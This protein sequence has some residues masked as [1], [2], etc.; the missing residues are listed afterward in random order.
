MTL[1]RRVAGNT[2]V[3][4]AGQ[5]VGIALS[6]VFVR[7]TTGHLGVEA[8]GEF[9]IILG[10][11]GIVT[12]LA[13][14]GVTTTLARELAKTP[15][16]ADELGGNLLRFRFVS[17]LT[18]ALATLAIL[19]V[20]PYSLETKIGLAISLVGVVFTT[21]A[22]FPKA[23]FQVHL[24]LQR[25][26][27]LDIAQKTLNVVAISV[28]IALDAELI[29][30][31]AML[32][33]VNLIVCIAA[34]TLSRPFWRPNARFTWAAARPLLRDTLGIGLVMMVGVLH[35]KGDSVLLSLLRPPEDVGD[36]TIAYRFVEQ[37]F[38]LPGVLLAAIFPI[39][40]RYASTN[41]SR[42]GP[43]MNR[44]FQVL[45]LAGLGA[46]LLIFTLSGPL[47]ELFAGPG[48]GGAVAP[49]RILAATLPV[50]F[51]SPVFYNLLIAVNRQRALLRL[52][53]AALAG[54]V[55]LNLVLIPPFGPEGAATATLI[56]ET[57]V[58]VGTY[59]IT[60]RVV[61]FHLDQLFV[62]RAVAAMVAG[63][64]AA[65]LLFGVSEVLAGIVGGAVFV[66]VAF[67]VRAVRSSEL[68]AL[69]S[70]TGPAG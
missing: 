43:L 62:L 69:L 34:F 41:D 45:L 3:Q 22:G 54:N 59:V 61:V 28:A 44:T 16:R 17:A 60:R 70:R 36:Y 39:L 68:R 12:V 25:Q 38:L 2:A 50:L 49:M 56:S 30:F 24:Q 42:L 47:V 19:P 7:L 1:A 9:A 53:F 64:L 31:V 10:V 13:D 11:G 35:F 65:A 48:F 21:L 27:M 20:L 67:A 46:S 51:V 6:L 8:F 33:V 5:F 18:Y 55:A 29:P 4:V 52:G 26:A 14:L 57:F 15:E 32:V 40:T 37:A 66:G 23:F 63:A 58:F